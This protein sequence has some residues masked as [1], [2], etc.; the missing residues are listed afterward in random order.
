M[1][2]VHPGLEVLELPNRGHAPF[3]TEPP[4]LDAI[5]AFLLRHA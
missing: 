3:L 1:R 4:A 5:K 2:Q